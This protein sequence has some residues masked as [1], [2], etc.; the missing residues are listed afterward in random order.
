M[1]KRPPVST[2]YKP[3]QSGNLLGGKAHS[4]IKKM[5]RKMTDERLFE[6]FTKYADMSFDEMSSLAKKAISESGKDIP[7]NIELLI[8]SAFKEG[9]KKGDLGKIQYLI[10]RFLGPIR[11]KIDHVSSDGSMRPDLT[12]KIIKPD[13]NETGN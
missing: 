1:G 13:S 9:I 4:P 8:M 3:G 2:S 7:P 12:V 10:D 5:I 6:I 11:Q